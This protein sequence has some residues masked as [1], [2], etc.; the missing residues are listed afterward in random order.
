MIAPVSL[1][2]LLMV[3]RLAP[4]QTAIVATIRSALTG[5][6]VK[7]HP[8]KV[9]VSEL[10]ART[11]VKAPGIGVGWSRIRRAAMTDGSYSLTVEWTSYVVAEAHVVGMKRVEKEAVALAIGSRLLAILGDDVACFWGLNGV[12][13]PEETPAPE[14]KPLFTVRDAS[15]GISYYTVTWTQSVV[16]VGTQHFP[17]GLGE[18]NPDDGTIDY[19]HA[20]ELVEMMPWIPARE[21]SDDA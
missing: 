11:V 5:V 7:P 21:V 10:V 8:G 15:Q 9:D 4:V 17:A 12:Y 13:P 6:E 2:Q 20:Q 3:D 1:D 19:L 14:L 16:D 18:A